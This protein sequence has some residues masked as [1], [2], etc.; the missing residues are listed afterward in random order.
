M[1]QYRV[2][3]LKTI[4]LSIFLFLVLTGKDLYSH[5]L[6]HKIIKGGFGIQALYSDGSPMSDSE[7]T[8]VAPGS[9]ITRP[10]ITGIT[11]KKG[12]FFFLPDQ[13]GKWKIIVDDGMGHRLDSGI[14]I[15]ETMEAVPLPGGGSLNMLQKIIMAICVVWGAIGTALYFYRKKGN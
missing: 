2:V 3:L 7:V 4:S 10:F 11:D 12:N 5:G 9:V 8:V 13:K 15:S 14:A 1:K 6:S